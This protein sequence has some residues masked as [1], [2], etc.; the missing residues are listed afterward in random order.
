MTTKIPGCKLVQNDAE[1]IKPYIDDKYSK[2]FKKYGTLHTGIDVTGSYVCSMSRGEVILANDNKVIIADGKSGF[3]Y[4]NMD[5]VYVQEGDII[6]PTQ[7]LG[8]LKDYVHVE[9]IS[10]EGTQWP[11]RVEGKTYYKHDPT[12]MIVNGYVADNSEP[13]KVVKNEYYELMD[14]YS[15]WNEAY[16]DDIVTENTPIEDINDPGYE[17][18][19]IDEIDIFNIDTDQPWAYPDDNLDT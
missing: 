10:S 14:D 16:S 1:I 12:D 8:G 7:V 5:D 6:K 3:C 9:Y 19:E 15:A 17:I 4:S 18:D 2:D 11:V 13:I